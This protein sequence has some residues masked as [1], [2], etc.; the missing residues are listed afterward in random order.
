MTKENTNTRYDGVLEPVPPL[1][2]EKYRAY[3]IRLE[4]RYGSRAMKSIQK[5][6]EG[7]SRLIA[8]LEGDIDDNALQSIAEKAVEQKEL[9]RNFEADIQESQP[10]DFD[11]NG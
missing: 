6:I 1:N 5:E 9:L 8:A 11:G 2:A 3:D 10:R 7:M 4:E